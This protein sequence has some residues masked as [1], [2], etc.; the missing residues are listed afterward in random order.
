[1]TVVLG[2]DLG[3]QSLKV[4]ACDAR[5]H[6]IAEASRAIAMDRPAPDRSQAA[7]YRLGL[8]F[9][10]YD[11]FGLDD[12]DLDEYGIFRSPA[13]LDAPVGITAWWQLQHQHGYA[14]LVTRILIEKTFEASTA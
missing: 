2:I 7:R 4:V 13:I 10:F 6:V 11:V 14:P 9:I 1:M 8:K 3:T 5:L 12:D